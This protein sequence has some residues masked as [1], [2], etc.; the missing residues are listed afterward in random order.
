MRDRDY[1]HYNTS[2]GIKIESKKHYEHEMKQRGLVSKEK[3]DDMARR[4][5]E[6]QHKTAT[7]SKEANQ[8][9]KSITGGRSTW[10]KGEKVSLTNRQIEGMKKV[11]LSFQ[12]VKQYQQKGG[13]K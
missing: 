10:N 7:L 2:M 12:D 9:I 4:A 11:G 1:V 8:V 5:R 6:S 13:F 3:A